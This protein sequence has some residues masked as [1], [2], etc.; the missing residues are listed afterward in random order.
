[1]VHDKFRMVLQRLHTPKFIF[2]IYN[3]IALKYIYEYINL[4][5]LINNNENIMII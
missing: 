4:L 5:R 2:C 3:K 1:M